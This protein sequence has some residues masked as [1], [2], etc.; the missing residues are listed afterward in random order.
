[1]RPTLTQ[2][3]AD[4]AA[5]RITSRTL[6][7]QC[8]NA[9]RQPEGEG[10]RTFLKVNAEQS[11]R[12]AD[13]HDQLRREGNP[14]SPFAGIPISIKDLFDVAGEVTTAGSRLLQ[15][16]PAASAD[17]A[18]V[19]RLRAAGFVFIGRSNMTEFAFSGLGLNIHYGTPANP[20]DR[21]VARIPGGSSSGAA[22][23]VAS[24]MAFAGLGTDTGGSCRIPAALCGIVG[25]KP[26]ASRVP[27]QGAFPLAPSLDSVGPLA[28]SVECCAILDAVLAAEPPA[29]LPA[30][31]LRGL[32]CAVPQSYVLDG[33]D[34]AVADA[35]GRSLQVLSAAGVRIDEIA[36]PEL[37][38]LPELNRRGGLAPPEA[39]ATHRDWIATRANEYDPRVLTRILR[40]KEQDAADYIQL[41][42]ARAN[43][44]ARVTASIADYAAILMPTTPCVAPPIDSLA[45]DAD[46]TQ[47]NT[48]MLRNPSAINFIDG[49]AISLPCHEPGSLPVGLM[50]AAVHGQDRRLLA[51]ARAVEERLGQTWGHVA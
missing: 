16:A 39:Y 34:A 50:L 2:L 27:L 49:C 45:T 29:A 25:F 30:L 24:G 9:I 6:V 47:A 33:L 8:L 1:M 28:N 43:L 41:L 17:A 48:Q 10:A 5:S 36:L 3:A 46:Y 40:G 19:A 4:L 12:A 35:F 31:E 15:S 32:R 13:Y 23:S 37:L 14:P 38:E 21:N 26:T 44:S 51:V 18:S 20:R 7:E 22:V 11:L 42:R